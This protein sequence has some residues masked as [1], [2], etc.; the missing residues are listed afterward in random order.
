MNEADYVIDDLT[1]DDWNYVYSKLDDLTKEVLSDAGY[2]EENYK[3]LGINAVEAILAQP[4]KWVVRH[5]GVPFFIFGFIETEACLPNFYIATPE[6]KKHIRFLH[7]YVP[8]YLN[9]LRRN[10]PDKHVIVEASERKDYLFRMLTYYG[11][12][13][14]QH[15]AG[16]IGQRRVILEYVNG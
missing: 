16:P 4:N 3:A 12:R 8:I 9:M 15:V 5:K 2:N 14:T 11:F 6:I 1:A 7:R 10:Y 13:L